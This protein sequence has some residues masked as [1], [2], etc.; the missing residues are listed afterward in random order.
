M[1]TP[2]GVSS[3]HDLICLGSAG[4]ASFPGGTVV[5]HAGVGVNYFSLGQ[6]L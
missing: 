1:S 2:L 3:V 4:C 6:V 5:T